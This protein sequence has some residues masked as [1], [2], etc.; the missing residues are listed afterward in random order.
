MSDHLGARTACIR[1]AGPDDLERLVALS[2]AF[3]DELGQ[4]VSE[5]ASWW[6]PLRR[7][8]CAAAARSVSAPTNATSRRSP[9]YRTL[10][11][12]AERARWDGGRQLWL[13]CPLGR[14]SVDVL[15]GS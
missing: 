6:L 5:G 7:R 8:A 3:R 11:F 10:G 9:L 14:D 1:L 15:T 4:A 12:R 2:R 13:E